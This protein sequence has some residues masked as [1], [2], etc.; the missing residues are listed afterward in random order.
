MTMPVVVQFSRCALRSRKI[1]RNRGSLVELTL[2]HRDSVALSGKSIN[3]GETEPGAFAWPFGR[4]QGLERKGEDFGRH[5]RARVGD[6]D[7]HVIT[8]EMVDLTVQGR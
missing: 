1:D 2:N 3:A 8:R 7:C 4:E 5:A 6:R